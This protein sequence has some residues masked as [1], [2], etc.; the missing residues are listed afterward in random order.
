MKRIL[1]GVAIVSLAGCHKSTPPAQPAAPAKPAP[2]PAAAPKPMAAVAPKPVA[3]PTVDPSSSQVVL[4]RLHD[5]DTAELDLAK[6]A[7]IHAR[8]KAAKSLAG[9]VIAARTKLD[10]Q[11]QALA[12]KL[13]VTLVSPSTLNLPAA[14]KASVQASD[15]ELS[16]AKA[17]TGADL[18]AAFS[19]AIDDADKREATM[20]D[21]AASKSTVADL[22][23]LATREDKTLHTQ[24]ALAERELKPASKKGHP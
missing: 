4:S 17:K 14:D 5:I 19:A 22:K 10:A 8:S 18:D 16:A 12:K 3:P 15:Q 2:A 11:V 23:S 6:Q 1:V 20:L 9:Q 13:N 21:A 24:E 7:K